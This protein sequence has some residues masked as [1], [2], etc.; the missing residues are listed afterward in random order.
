MALGNSLSRYSTLDTIIDDVSNKRRLETFPSI[1]SSEIIDNEND[2]F[3]TFTDGMRLD[4]LAEDFLGDSSYWWAICIANDF[5]L[6][7]G[8]DMIP[9]T[10]LR[11]P[12]N[13]SKIL[14]VIQNKA[15]SDL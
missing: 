12:L 6:P 11:I 10:I 14:N 15:K 13:I 7:F 5:N 8:A 9:G 4:R 1:K 2:I 3:I